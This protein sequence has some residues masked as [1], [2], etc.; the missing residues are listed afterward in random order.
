[1]F[2]SRKV[3]MIDGCRMC[4]RPIMSNETIY[5]YSEDGWQRTP[6]CKNCKEKIEKELE[7]DEME[8]KSKNGLFSPCSAPNEYCSECPHIERCKPVGKT[9]YHI[10]EFVPEYY[11]VSKARLIQLLMAEV[12]KK[13]IGK[14]DIDKYPEIVKLT[15]EA[16]KNYDIDKGLEEFRKE[17]K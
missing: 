11:L 16:L 2:D 7:N 1:M 14:C 10:K 17:V 6:V 8:N 4:H 12:I 15:L 13:S 3:Y 5:Y 9:I